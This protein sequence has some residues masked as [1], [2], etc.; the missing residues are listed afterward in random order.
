MIMAR[1]ARRHIL[2]GTGFYHA[3]SRGNRK[4]DI[5]RSDIDYK[6]F[7]SLMGKYSE[8][9][10]VSIHAF[11]LM[12]NHFH[13]L[14][15]A[16]GGAMAKF[17]QQLLSVYTLRTNK[18]YDEVGHLFQGRYQSKPIDTD[19]YAMEISRYIH[20]NPVDLNA[21]LLV[22]NYSWSSLAGYIDPKLKNSF[23]KTDF[24]LSHFTSALAYLA[25]VKKGS[26]LKS[27]QQWGQSNIALSPA[28]K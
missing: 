13:M 26:S 8:K 25:F 15:K 28:N 19:T 1:V 14:I 24:I 7:L 9:H 17:Y 23:I 22:E 21:S 16:D 11:C 10:N 20:N 27:I 5:F 2:S 4:Q 3:Y 6:H 12:P 18:I